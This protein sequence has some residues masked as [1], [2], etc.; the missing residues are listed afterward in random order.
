MSE[1]KCKPT[2]MN[3]IIAHCHECMGYYSDGKQDCE[4]QHCKFYKWMPWAKLE[5]DLNWTKYYHNRIGLVERRPPTEKQIAAGKRL[6]SMRKNT[7][8]P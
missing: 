5:A 1:I 6:A 3:A 8:K 4:C 2:P 7:K